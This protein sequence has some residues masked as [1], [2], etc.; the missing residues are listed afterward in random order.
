MLLAVLW[1]VTSGFVFSLTALVA[2]HYT[3]N[4]LF[5]PIK[6]TI[7]GLFVS[8]ILLMFGYFF[9]TNVQRYSWYDDLLGTM[10][11]VCLISGSVMATTAFKYGKGGPI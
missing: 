1:A 5:K 10:I 6:L 7:D 8:G 4:G 2:K 9:L 11:G 3:L